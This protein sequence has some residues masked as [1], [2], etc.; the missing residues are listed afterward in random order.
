MNQY[1]IPLSEEQLRCWVKQIAEQHTKG[2]FI[3]DPSSD[4]YPIIYCNEAFSKMTGYTNDEIVGQS[5][6]L[7][8]GKKTNEAKVCRLQEKLQRN[9][10]FQLKL[11][12]YKKDGTAF[13]H[14]MTCHPMKD[15]NNI[16]QFLLI[17][18]ENTTTTA[19]NRMVSKLEVEVYEQ[20]ENDLD[21]TMIYQLI[22]EKIE[23]HYLRSAY[24]V[25]QLIQPD[26]S[27][28][29]IGHGSLPLRIAQEL[30]TKHRD[31]YSNTYME[32]LNETMFITPDHRYKHFI[33][34]DEEVE[35]IGCW[36][37][38]ILSKNQNLKGYITLYF[39]EFEKFDKT[40]IHFF[41]RLA[42]LI[43]LAQKYGDQKRELKKLAYYDTATN[44]PNAHYFRMKL[45]EWIK[46]G[47]EGILILIQPS[48]YS[49][50]VDLYGRS[51]GD[52]LLKQMVERLNK[53][54]KQHIEFIGRYSNSLII[55]SCI[56]HDKLQQYDSRVCALTSIPYFLSEKETNITLKIGISY[57]TEHSTS[58]DSI[59]QADIALSKAR[60]QSGT[61]MAYF[62]QEIDEKL[63]IE[64]D[65][66]NQLKH[67][68]TND[69][70]T[71]H[72]QPKLNMKSG[73]IDSFEAL[74]RWNSSTLGNVAP[75]TFIP[76]AEQS[77]YIKE[78]DIAVLRK[79][80][81][82]LEVRINKGLKVVPI[83]INISPVHF[84]DDLFLD[85][86]KEI[87]KEYTVP[88]NLIKIELTESIELVDFTKAKTILTELKH[89]GIN[90]AIDDFGVGF[91]SLSYLPKLPFSEIKIDRSF[92]SA[93]NDPGMYAV[94]QTI[95]QLA[96]N[97][98][99]KAV[100]EGIETLEQYILLKN[101]GC[102]IGQGYFLH[103]PM[104]LE[105]AGALLDSL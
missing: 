43:T 38:P 52:E 81:S 33:H 91:S 16:V 25:I 53:H 71:I 13:W 51:M 27:L 97:L 21:D 80:L 54:R 20:L 94:I 5:L 56:D 76:L 10:S 98:Q 29:V 95:I 15:T 39:D 40:D 24:C 69:E 31:I 14:E 63:K 37:T 86:F 23:K 89:L 101:M 70:F 6:D 88:L 68:L 47:K 73:R 65:T 1:R 105:V 84:Y 59:R 44:I 87:I 99:M 60:Q 48:E 50:I 3:I 72:L 103:K 92:I 17:Y 32:K 79:A 45:D 75:S 74:A 62:M 85:Q 19:L 66:L 83:A 78:I 18:C 30:T 12:H 42:L 102:H 55:A 11:I 77:G 9:E 41:N 82:W 28:Q 61:S 7:L 34:S 22:T 2:A 90:S 104:P 46:Q 57:F 35:I 96:T 64:M 100:A 93:L 49:N 4:N 26:H 8:N 58:D 67:G 36:I